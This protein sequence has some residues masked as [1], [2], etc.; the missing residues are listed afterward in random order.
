MK[1]RAFAYAR[2]SSLA[3]AHAA[4]AAAEGDASYISG[5][6][7]LVPAL[8]MRLQAPQVIIDLAGIA[9]MRGVALAEG[10]LRIGALTRHAEALTH[11]LI[12]AHAPLLAKAAPFVAHPAIRNRGTIGG[13][14]ALADPASEFP[15]MM[16]AM[17][18]EMEISSPEG[19]R[20]V[21]AEDYF[22]DLYQTAIGPGEILMA[23]H[24]PAAGT[25]HV[26]AFDEMARRRGDY[27]MVG[28]GILAERNGAAI[29]SIRIALFSVGPTPVRARG[30]EAALSGR[31][32]DAQSIADA[33]NALD[34]DID[35]LDDAEIP[36]AMRRHLARVLLG[37]LLR[38]L[39]IAP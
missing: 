18:A 2:P 6:Q 21:A 7:S 16:L 39:E 5:G 1:A 23:M 20:R 25:A 28:G 37:R 38:Q 4:F 32:L 17:G 19:S 31:V 3:E 33:Q 11:P 8:A 15:A 9:E 14:V 30:A 13:S 29:A 12:R 24:M 36:A 35:P 10:T 26:A 27:A 34:G 22:Q